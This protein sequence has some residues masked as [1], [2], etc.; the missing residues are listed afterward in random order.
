V[1]E[2]EG[3]IWAYIVKNENDIYSI[4]PA[5]IQ[6]YIGE[7]PNTQV[8]TESAPGNIGQWVGWRIVKEYADKHKDFSVQQIL[9]APAKTIFEEAK[10]KPK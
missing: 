8:M 9:E 2:N 1:E 10:Y 4:D 6:T 5:T 7:A 3:N